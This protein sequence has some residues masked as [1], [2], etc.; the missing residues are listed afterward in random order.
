MFIK[1]LEIGDTVANVQNEIGTIE[2]VQC[3]KDMPT[4][5]TVKW[6]GKLG[7]GSR[8][9]HEGYELRRVLRPLVGKK[10]KLTING[11]DIPEVGHISF[12]YRLGG[13]TV[14]RTTCSHEWVDVGFN[15]SNIVCKKCNT[16]KDSND[17]FQI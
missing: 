9:T 1:P 13:I 6:D 10:V 5:Y 15:H 11:M 7:V 17:P 4:I 12:D 16:P 3:E 2:Y 8:T 14:S